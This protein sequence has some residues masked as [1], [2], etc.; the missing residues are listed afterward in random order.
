[1]LG[2]FFTKP[3]Q[4]SLFR[5]FRSAILGEESHVNSLQVPPTAPTEERV[6]VQEVVQKTVQSGGRG[7]DLSALKSGTSGSV[8]DQSSDDVETKKDANSTKSTQ[9][10]WADVVKGRKASNREARKE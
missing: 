7:S 5:K 3:L 10:T 4:G 1:M 2:D 9:C 8:S 6:G